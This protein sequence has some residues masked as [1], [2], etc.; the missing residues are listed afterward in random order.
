MRYLDGPANPYLAQELRDLAP[1]TALDAGCGAGAEA[2]WLA[3]RGWSVTGVDISA[4]GLAVARR[5][6]PAVEWIEADLTTWHPGRPFDLVMT[7]Y[8]HPAMP[9]LEFYDRIAQWVAPGGALLIVGHLDDGHHPA[10]VSLADVVS[11]LDGWRIDSAGEY[12]RGS[13][14]DVVVRATK[15]GA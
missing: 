6:E 14:S 2:A 15:V 12:A 11:R 8:A 7:H 3:S 5:R 4:E 10:S 13:L 9:H 1:G